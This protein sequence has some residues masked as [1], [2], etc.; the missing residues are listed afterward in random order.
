[1]V[2]G[3][4]Q[5]VSGFM[6]SSTRL[7]LTPVVNQRTS[8]QGTG[9]IGGIRGGAL[10]MSSDCVCTIVGAGRIG[11]ALRD[12]GK[13]AGFTDVMVGRQDSIPAD[14]KGPVYVA[15]RNDALGS[16]IDKCPVDRRKDLVFFETDVSIIIRTRAIPE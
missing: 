9:R 16:V 13:D 1:M 7:P 12:M 14:G 5:V 3:Q 15:T 8:P 4:L 6:L 11:Q 10:K 2:W